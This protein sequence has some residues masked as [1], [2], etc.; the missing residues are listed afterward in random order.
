MNGDKCIAELHL[1][2]PGFIY[3]ACRQFTKH[4]ERIK[5]F[6]ETGHLKHLY[7]NELYKPCFGHDPGYSDSED[8]AK[9]TIS[10]KV[11][12][13]KAY[14]IIK[15]PKYDGYLRALTSMVYKFFDKKKTGSG[16]SV[17]EKLAEEL[18]KPLIKNLKQKRVYA[19]FKDNIWA[20]D[21]AEIRSLS[22]KNKNFRYLLC[23]IDAF[24]KKMF[25]PNMLG[26]SL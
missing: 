14:E 13:E 5:T 21:L 9:I 23:V 4:H 22:S 19:R 24:T 11:L 2:Q 12:R 8:L 1:K 15:N 3:R 20:A 25:L 26:L 6:R 7:R 18:H 10:D 16:A 17:N